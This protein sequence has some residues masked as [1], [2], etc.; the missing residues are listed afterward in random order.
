MAVIQRKQN[1]NDNPDFKSFKINKL[2]FKSFL[3]NLL[4]NT[5]THKINCYYVRNKS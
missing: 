3:I 1:N 5:K 2:F 4:T